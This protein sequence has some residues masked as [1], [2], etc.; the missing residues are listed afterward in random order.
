[1][2][3]DVWLGLQ[4]V[5]V[6]DNVQHQPGKVVAGILAVAPDAAQRDELA[7]AGVDALVGANATLVVVGVVVLEPVALEELAGLL[8]VEPPCCQVALVVRVE[9]LVD[10]PR[11]EPGSRV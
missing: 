8:T 1:M 10:A 2:E 5:H 11:R 3:P 4:Q 7:E 9:V 6:L